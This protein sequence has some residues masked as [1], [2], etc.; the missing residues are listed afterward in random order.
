MNKTN[1]LA[2]A[3]LTAL[4]IGVLIGR[5]SSD[6]TDG[7]VNTSA[8]GERRSSSWRRAPEAFSPRAARNS[9]SWAVSSRSIIAGRVSR[10][11][12]PGRAGSV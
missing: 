3:V 5:A 10:G 6:S 2:L 8:G 12:D 4:G 7:A 11:L 1:I 9:R